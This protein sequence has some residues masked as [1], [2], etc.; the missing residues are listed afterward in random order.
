[1]I[2]IGATLLVALDLVVRWMRARE[3]PAQTRMSEAGADGSALQRLLS[4]DWLPR[5]LYRRLARVLTV[6]FVGAAIGIVVLTGSVEETAVVVLLALSLVL[7]ELLQDVLPSRIFG[8]LRLPLEAAVVLVLLTTL[9]A[10]TGGATS[11]YF[12]GYILLVAIAALSVSELAAAALALF[13]AAAYL[14]AVAAGADGQAL[15]AAE[16]G[17]VAFNLISI[18]LAA[19]FGSMIGREHRRSRAAALELVRLDPMTQALT[20]RFFDIALEAEILR[21]NRMGR[22]FSVILSDLD[23]LKFTND[24]YGYEAGDKLIKSAADAIQSVTRAT[25]SV[26]RNSTAADEFFVLLP[27]TDAAGADVVAENIRTKIGALELT[28]KGVPIVS[29]ASLGVVTFPEDGQQLADLMEHG[30]AALHVAKRLGKNRVE[31]Y[32]QPGRPSATD[33]ERDVRQQR[34]RSL[35]PAATPG[36]APWETA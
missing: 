12:F 22:K 27:E 36:A 9:V 15:S 8:R 35:S 29:T 7:I 13:T 4:A 18:A 11:L 25:D 2:A 3:G 32:E 19:Y 30:V 31:H 6:V 1:M 28:F 26:G 34:S 10:L 21:S 23:G 17:A 33:L 5:G 20:K 14:V 24:T 16:V